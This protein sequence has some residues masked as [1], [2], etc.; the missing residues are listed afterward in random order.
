MMTVSLKSSNPKETFFLI[1]AC[2]ETYDLARA[3]RSLLQSYNTHTDSD[4]P[5][6][7]TDRLQ[8]NEPD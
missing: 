6:E 2:I 7:E 1:V 4:T 8:N 5:A 3:V